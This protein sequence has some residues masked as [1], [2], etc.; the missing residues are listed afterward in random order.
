MHETL[1]KNWNDRVKPGELVYV[2][3]DFSF[4]NPN[5]TRKVMERLNGKKILIKG[6]HDMPAHKAIQAGFDEVHEN[7]FIWLTASG[8]KKYK[9]FLSHFP[10]RHNA[11]MWLKYKIFGGYW[12]TRYNHKRMVDEGNWLLHGHT[13]QRY[14]QKRRMI[15][16]GVDAWDYRPVSHHEIIKLIEETP[17]ETFMSRLIYNLHGLGLLPKRKAHRIGH[18]KAKGKGDKRPQISRGSVLP[19]SRPSGQDQGTDSGT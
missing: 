5:L 8:G 7:I 11:L 6:N 18:D 4:A 19:D 9:V 13:H 14:K 17:N 12:D 3:G 15:H 1:I 2:L 16:V 10:Y